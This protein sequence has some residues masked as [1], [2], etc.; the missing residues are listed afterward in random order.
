MDINRK[1]DLVT[2][3]SLLV[4]AR[5]NS[6]GPKLAFIQIITLAY[7]QRPLH[8][9]S[10]PWRCRAP[11]PTPP[12]ISP[13]EPPITQSHHTTNL[14]LNPPFVQRKHPQLPPHPTPLRSLRRLPPDGRLPNITNQ[15][16]SLGLP[17]PSPS[18]SSSSSLGQPSTI[19]S[20][21]QRD[22]AH[23]YLLVALLPALSRHSRL[24][25]RLQGKALETLH[26]AL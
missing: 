15:R 10:S 23:P 5:L 7:A 4:P 20:F 17:S 13:T 21:V 11:P 25:R 3:S 1:L 6:G 24:R 12:M 8:N 16:R 26:C 19:S 18:Y 9:E 14:P 22:N 2:C